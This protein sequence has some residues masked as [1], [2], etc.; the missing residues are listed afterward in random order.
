MSQSQSSGFR[1]H[2]RPQPGEEPSEPLLWFPWDVSPAGHSDHGLVVP[3]AESAPNAL[4]LVE[5]CL[6][7]SYLLQEQHRARPE[8]ALSLFQQQAMHRALHLSCGRGGDALA[9]G[10]DGREPQ[11][12]LGSS[13]A[14]LTGRV[15]EHGTSINVGPGQGLDHH[16][17]AGDLVLRELLQ[18]CLHT[19]SLVTPMSPRAAPQGHGTSTRPPPHADAWPWKQLQ[20]ARGEPGSQVPWAGALTR[21]P[22]SPSA[23]P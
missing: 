23:A 3:V 7:V 15:P 22:P 20:G 1:W 10:S 21:G 16:R 2:H 18:G 9:M 17:H 12:D 11:P 19:Q 14:L 8:L 13:K 4:L 6:R 5:I